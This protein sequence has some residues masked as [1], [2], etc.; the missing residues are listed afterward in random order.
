VSCPPGTL[1]ESFL[2]RAEGSSV[3]FSCG[4]LSRPAG[5]AA[6]ATRRRSPR[7]R[8][9]RPAANV[10]RR[11][12]DPTHGPSRH[13]SVGGDRQGT[14][15]RSPAQLALTSPVTAGGRH[16]DRVRLRSPH[17]V[18]R[19]DPVLKGSTTSVFSTV[20]RLPELLFS[21][22]QGFRRAANIHTRHQVMLVSAVTG[23]GSMSRTYA[24]LTRA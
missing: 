21:S 12:G 7:P 8:A 13:V 15:A 22:G 10:G 4:R 18:R 2:V 23:K 24:A 16:D 19:L 14:S 5:A 17:T 11:N 1:A 9:G 3:L 20:N 6:T